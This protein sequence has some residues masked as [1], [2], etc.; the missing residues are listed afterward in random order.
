M[1]SVVG[2]LYNTLHCVEG[3]RFVQFM[4]NR[5][6]HQGIKQSLYEAM[7]GM[8]AKVCL[9]TSFFPDDVEINSE[10]ELEELLNID[11]ITK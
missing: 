3:L 1:Y 7:F 10:E 6:Y 2:Y 8:P 5:A 4:K 11:S 9:K